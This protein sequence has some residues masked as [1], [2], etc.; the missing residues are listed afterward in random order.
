[1]LEEKLWE[2]TSELAMQARKLIALL[3]KTIVRG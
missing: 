2:E 1:M 3:T